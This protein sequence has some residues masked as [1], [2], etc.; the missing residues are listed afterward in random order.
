[1][2]RAQLKGAKL[3]A[4]IEVGALHLK[5]Q[6]DVLDATDEDAGQRL[7]RR[8]AHQ[9]TLAAD[10]RVCEWDFGG[11]VLNLDSR[12]DGGAQMPAE[13]TLDLSVV[14]LVAPLLRLQAKLLNATDR[15]LQP[16]RDH[17]WL[18][19]QAWLV[20]RYAGAL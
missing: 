8:A 6:I 10:Y 15:H 4:T 12:P 5:A 19:R 11:N 14:W 16:A 7:N 20:V 3:S 13:T 2:S 18:G 9:G 17:Q 1:M